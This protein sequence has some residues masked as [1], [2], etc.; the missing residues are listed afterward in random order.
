MS[1]EFVCKDCRHL[2]V[3]EGYGKL[4]GNFLVASILWIFVVPGIIYSIWRRT[5]KGSCAKC[6][7]TSLAS[8]DSDYGKIA[9]E[10]FYMKEFAK[11]SPPKPKI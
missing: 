7:S 4:R 2:G 1:R 8:L 3:P 6:A 5:G 10:E 11:N 9:L